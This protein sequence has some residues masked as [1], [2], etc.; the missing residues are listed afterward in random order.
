MPAIVHAIH[1]ALSIAISNTFAIGIA[2][3]IVAA[4]L[5]MFLRE[6][7]APA[8]ELELGSDGQRGASERTP[9]AV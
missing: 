2:A 8:T 7:P 6:A 3:S 1:A 4:A 9:S 5:V